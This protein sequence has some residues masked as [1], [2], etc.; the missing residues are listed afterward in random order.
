MNTAKSEPI[1]T[2]EI[3]SSDI[4]NMKYLGMLRE[5]DKRPKYIT[6]PYKTGPVWLDPNKGIKAMYCGDRKIWQNPDYQKGGKY[7]EDINCG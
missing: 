7:Y 5:K 2:H 6:V 1:Y 4:D 3:A